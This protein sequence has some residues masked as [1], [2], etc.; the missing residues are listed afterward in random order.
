MTRDKVVLSSQ[1][2]AP[3]LLAQE[4]STII[5]ACIAT[6]TYRTGES[7]HPQPGSPQAERPQYPEDV[8]SRMALVAARLAVQVLKIIQVDV[9]HGR[10]LEMNPALAPAV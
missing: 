2:A 8:N 4:T 10:L 1:T 3:E 6:S 9:D 5:P 7:C